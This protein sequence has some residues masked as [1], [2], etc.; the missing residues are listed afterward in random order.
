MG[1]EP[2]ADLYQ[3]RDGCFCIKNEMDVSG[4]NQLEVL[5][6]S[7]ICIQK[8]DGCFRRKSIRNSTRISYLH[9]NHD[10]SLSCSM[11][12]VYV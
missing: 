7:H 10:I 1:R 6:V 9:V 4:E 12:F 8:R 2:R 5:H 11:L 3:K